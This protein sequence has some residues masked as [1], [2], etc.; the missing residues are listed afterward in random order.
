MH[1]EARPHHRREAPVVVTLPLAV[2][3]LMP[4]CFIAGVRLRNDT[5]AR[6]LAVCIL[7]CMP[8]QPWTY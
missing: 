3:G 6:L 5:L 7:L 8:L 2:V 1:A 4:R